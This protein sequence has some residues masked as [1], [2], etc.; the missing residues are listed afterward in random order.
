MICVFLSSFLNQNHLL[1]FGISSAVCIVSHYKYASFEVAGLVIPIRSFLYNNIRLSG[2]FFSPRP[3]RSTGI[4][5]KYARWAY[6][7]SIYFFICHQ[8][9]SH[10]ISLSICLSEH[11]CFAFILFF[12]CFPLNWQTPMILLR[13]LLHERSLDHS[14]LIL[15]CHKT[16]KYK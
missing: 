9:N 14:T 12:V 13:L 3:N 15:R 11:S 10:S 2:A 8:M 4:S 6:F 16:A 7:K 1:F 5:F